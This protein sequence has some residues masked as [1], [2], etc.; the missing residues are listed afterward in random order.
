PQRAGDQRAQAEQHRHLRGGGGQGVA[1]L[2]ILEQI[3]DGSA[4]ADESSQEGEPGDLDVEVED[5]L[6]RTHGGFA[7]RA[8]DELRRIGKAGDGD[9]QEDDEPGFE[10]HASPRTSG[11]NTHKP[12]ET[13][14]ASK[15]SRNLIQK[16][17]TSSVSPMSSAAVPRVP[18]MRTGTT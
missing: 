6:Y 16:L 18:A 8:Q 7:R 4:C 2:R 3:G 11:S 1:P 5:L 9:D 14:T 12:R 17:L 10:L 13:N 15:T